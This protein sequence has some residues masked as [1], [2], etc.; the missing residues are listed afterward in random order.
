[1]GNDYQYWI[2]RGMDHVSWDNCHHILLQLQTGWLNWVVVAFCEYI[3]LYTWGIFWYISPSPLTVSE[4]FGVLGHGWIFHPLP[5]YTRYNKITISVNSAINVFME[6]ISLII[7]HC[8]YFQWTLVGDLLN[9]PK[10][11]INKVQE[12]HLWYWG[13]VRSYWVVH[14]FFT[15]TPSILRGILR[16]T[17]VSSSS[18]RSV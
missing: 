9:H 7:S 6:R 1:M 16:S 3:P 2:L 15:T 8:D 14:N 12:A 11:C 5:I 18:G 4:K 13:A 17:T 10:M